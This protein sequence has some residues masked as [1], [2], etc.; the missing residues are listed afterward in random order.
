MLSTNFG[1]LLGFIAGHYLSFF[2]VPKCALWFPAISFVT[3]TFFPESPIYLLRRGRV[4]DAVNAMQ[5]YRNCR[6]M[7]KQKLE[8]YRN[9][10]DKLINTK[11][12]HSSGRNITWQDFRMSR[13][14]KP[15]D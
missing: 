8:F 14:I 5:I 12:D 7:S 6:R 11:E 3:L 4:N 2:T 13:I 1:V 10:L 9:E 15:I